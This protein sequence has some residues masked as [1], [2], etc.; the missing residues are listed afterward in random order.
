MK[1]CS[2]LFIKSINKIFSRLSVCFRPHNSLDPIKIRSDTSVNRWNSC[3]TE[4]ASIRSQSDDVENADCISVRI[5]KWAATDKKK[6]NNNNDFAEFYSIEFFHLSPLHVSS[7]DRRII[8]HSKTF[9]SV[10]IQLTFSASPPAQ[11]CDGKMSF[12]SS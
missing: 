6:K 7:K 11:M 5:L 10:K 12:S 1:K 8:C 3:A 4:K 2:I 9:F